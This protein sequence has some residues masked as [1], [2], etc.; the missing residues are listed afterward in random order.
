MKKISSW[1]P[2]VLVEWFGQK[3]N[4]PPSQQNHLQPIMTRACTTRTMMKGL[5]ELPVK[6]L[7]VRSLPKERYLSGCFPRS[8]RSESLK[9]TNSSMAKR[10]TITSP[11]AGRRPRAERNLPVLKQLEAM[12]VKTHEARSELQKPE[13]A[14]ATRGWSEDGHFRSSSWRWCRD[15]G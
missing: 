4:Q 7:A 5:Y 3:G 12:S 14:F 13:R 15:G 8:G 11:L 9:R 2:S 1:F 10:W 6:R